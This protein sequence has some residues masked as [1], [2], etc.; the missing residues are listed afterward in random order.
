MV[1]SVAKHAVIASEQKFVGK[2]CAVRV[3]RV[4]IAPG[5]FAPR[6]V[7]E[8][9]SAVCVLPVDKDGNV[10]IYLGLLGDLGLNASVLISD[11]HT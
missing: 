7:V 11:D 6:E 2:I 10:D 8:H 9:C 4:E 1:V 5:V 3:D